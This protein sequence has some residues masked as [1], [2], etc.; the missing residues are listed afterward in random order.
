MLT[1]SS[2]CSSRQSLIICWYFLT[3]T[4]F[5]TVQRQHMMFWKC[6]LTLRL[7]AATCFIQVGDQKGFMT[8]FFTTITIWRLGLYYFVWRSSC[9]NECLITV[10]P[11]PVIQLN[12]D[13]QFLQGDV[14]VVPEGNLHHLPD[15]L[16]QL[17]LQLLDDGQVVRLLCVLALKLLQIVFYGLV[18]WGCT[19]IYLDRGANKVMVELR[20]RRRKTHWLHNSHGK[21]NREHSWQK[22]DELLNMLVQFVL[23]VL[24]ASAPQ[25]LCG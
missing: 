24:P 4:Q 17:A 16:I 6:M 8:I 15:Q 9:V 12:R 14:G 22:G 7:M 21:G 5:K 13:G 23:S 3:C 19:V 25:W 2:L 20:G 10:L 1:Y 11:V 18:Q